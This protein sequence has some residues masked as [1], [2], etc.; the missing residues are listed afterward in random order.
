MAALA[1]MLD[2]ARAL[3]R[4]LL[5]PSQ[6]KAV[7]TLFHRLRALGRPASGGTPE[8]RRAILLSMLDRDGRGLEIGPS[9]NPVA[10][11]REGFRVEVV[12]HAD[13][14][15]LVG[16]Y[17]GH[18]VDVDLIEDVD[19]VWSGESY[20]ELTGKSSHYDWIIASHVIEHVPDLVGFVKACAEV[21]HDGGVLALAVPD[22][23]FCFDRFR[24]LTGL[25]GLV[26]AHLEGR[27]DHSPGSVADYSLNVVALRGRIGWKPGEALAATTADFGF[28]HGAEDAKAAIQARPGDLSY[29]DIHAWCFTASSFRLLVEDLYQ[30]G[31]IPLREARF[32]GRDDAEFFIALS[33]EGG[34][35]DV[36]RME[37][38][39]AIESEM[40]VVRVGEAVA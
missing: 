37:L 21:L 27:R 1:G 22:K 7:W 11:K 33:R 36:G 5:S 15:T 20:A 34:G 16:K 39:R 23:R 9:H 8:D 6:R 18:G 28:V 35:P 32:L 30:L 26:D 10:P 17:R 29:R 31:M 13:R 25:Q 3:L 4:R 12:D 14:A 19:F 38:L 2:P 24:A 40:S